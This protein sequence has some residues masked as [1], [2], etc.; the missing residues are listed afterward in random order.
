MRIDFAFEIDVRNFRRYDYEDYLTAIDSLPETIVHSCSKV[1]VL[2]GIMEEMEV[3]R[4]SVRQ[5][6]KTTVA[7]L[8]GVARAATTTK[9]INLPR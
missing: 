5:N 6:A 1:T 7:S 9:T 8:C 3:R 2:S 4:S